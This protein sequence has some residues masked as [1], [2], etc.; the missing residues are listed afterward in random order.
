MARSGTKDHCADISA[1]HEHAHRCVY[2]IRGANSFACNVIYNRALTHTRAPLNL[3]MRTHCGAAT[4][5]SPAHI[6]SPLTLDLPLPISR[7]P[8]SDQA[9]SLAQPWGM[10]SFPL[11]FPHSGISASTCQ[12][13]LLKLRN[14]WGMREWSGPWA[15]QSDEWKTT[16]GQKV[17]RPRPA[18][19]HPFPP[20]TLH[21]L[22]T[23]P[24]RRLPSPALPQPPAN[25]L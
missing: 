6:V 23:P 19:P 15:D 14:P 12:I 21:S 9:A 8:P 4:V 16:L 7:P 2:C 11:T 18:S 20:H 25:S 3:G 24:L 10:P 13:K 1:G 17:R 5:F 22:P